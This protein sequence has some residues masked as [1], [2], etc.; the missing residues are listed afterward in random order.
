MVMSERST[1]AGVFTDPAHVEQAI[2]E[3]RLVGFSDD[4][5]SVAR[6]G[7]PAGGFLESLKSLFRGQETTTAM[8][9]DDFRS[10]GVPEQDAD[11][12]QR[13]LDAGRTIVLVRAADLQQE[14]LAILRKNGAY[15]AAMRRP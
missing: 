7:A 6:G 2:N 14:A 13:E 15:D 4:E 1:V 11:Y 3:L 10:M 5:I 12:Y 8:T 9:A